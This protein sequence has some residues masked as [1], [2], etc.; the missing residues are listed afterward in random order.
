M[1]NF[2]QEDT[3]IAQNF[4]L[5]IKGE[6]ITYLSGVSGL[7]IAMEVAEVVQAAP[8]G[9]KVIRKMLGTHIKPPDLSLTR[10]A[11]TDMGKDAMWGWFN[12]IYNKGMPVGNRGSERKDGSIVIYDSTGAEVARFNFYNGWP[13]KIATDQLSV[14]SNDPVKETITLTIE[15]LE[16][17]K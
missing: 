6:I 9:K 15:R 3:L 11:P 16:R 10:V 5:E 4:F 14:D 2:L 1:P 12:E 7:D 8:D 17:T 13:S